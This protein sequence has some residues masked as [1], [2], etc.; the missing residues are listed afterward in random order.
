VHILIKK[1]INSSHPGALEDENEVPD[2]LINKYNHFIDGIFER[3]NEHLKR[4]FDPVNV[5][6]NNNASSTKASS[7]SKNGG[8]K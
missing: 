6:L 5:E 4:S 1:I 7:K 8:K 2:I 3:I